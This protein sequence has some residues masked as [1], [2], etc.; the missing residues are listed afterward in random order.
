[1]GSIRGWLDFPRVRRVH[2][3]AGHRLPRRLPSPTTSSATGTAAALLIVVLTG[4]FGRF[5]YGLVA[6]VPAGR[7]WS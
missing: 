6:V 2:E 3:P 7:T 5:I 4:I 1:M